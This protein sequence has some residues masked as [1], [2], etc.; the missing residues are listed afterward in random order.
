VRKNCLGDVWG[1]GEIDSDAKTANLQF[2][3]LSVTTGKILND[4]IFI[5]KNT[6]ETQGISVY[7]KK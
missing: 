7:R 4:E 6:R 3:I 5:T 2:Y 1:Q